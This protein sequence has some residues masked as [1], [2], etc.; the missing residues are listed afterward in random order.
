MAAALVASDRVLIPTQL[1]HLA[2]DGVMRLAAVLLRVA[3][4]LNRGL[5]DF[6]VAPVQVDTRVQLHKQVLARLNAEFGPSRVFR[7]I[8][9]D[10]ALAE[11][12]GAGAAV[13]SYRP[14]SRGA[15]DY[16]ALTDDILAVW[17]A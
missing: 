16:A 15:Q 7:G 17:G 3:T 2:Y 11:A 9:S 10:I 1:H 12:F 14:H 6:A 4:L 8:R 13:R 5:A